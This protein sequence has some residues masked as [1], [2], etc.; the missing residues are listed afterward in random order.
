MNEPFPA[1][2]SRQEKRRGLV[3]AC[4]I[5]WR[6][7]AIPGTGVNSC[8]NEVIDISGSK[9]LPRLWQRFFSTPS[10]SRPRQQAQLRVQPNTL[11]QSA[12]AAQAVRV[13]FADAQRR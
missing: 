2:F 12:F 5:E 7:L 6:D 1:N 9:T 11:I 10:Q 13:S 3:L 8:E 4:R